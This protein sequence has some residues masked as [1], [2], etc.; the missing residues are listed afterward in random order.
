MQQ[1][2]HDSKKKQPDQ[3]G[4]DQNLKPLKTLLR[5]WKDS[6]RTGENTPNHISDKRP[7][8]TRKCN[9][10]KTNSPI[11]EISQRLQH[12][13]HHKGYM[14]EKVTPEKMFDI[15]SH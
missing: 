9:V 13:L 8:D 1:Q 6:H 3:T 14:D 2:S 12:V 15:I 10:K 7:V 11:W 4:L 5:E